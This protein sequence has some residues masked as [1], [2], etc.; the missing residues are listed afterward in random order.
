MKNLLRSLPQAVRFGV[1]FL[2]LFATVLVY[3]QC[4]PPTPTSNGVSVNCGST[5]TLTASGSPNYIWY[6]DA[7]GTN[8]IGSGAS[9][10]TPA[11]TS[12]TT[13]YL[14]GAAGAA[15]SGTLTYNINT[16]GQLINMNSDC[17][18]GSRYNGCSGNTGFSWV[19]AVP[20]GAT[21]T[22]VQI[23]LSVGVECQGGTRTTSING[24]NGPTFNTVNN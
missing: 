6:S 23:Q 20:A 7:A 12:N 13:F 2:G 18:S 3:G 4:P 17:G 8:M 15:Q 1:T 14:R 11:L 24:V 19:S 5:A 21:V 9:F 16:I 10:T 22:S